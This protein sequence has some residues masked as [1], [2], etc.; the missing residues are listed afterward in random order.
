MLRYD[1][2]NFLIE[3]NKYNKY[4]EIGVRN[5]DDCFNII[6]CETKYSVDPCYEFQGYRPN[7][8]YTSDE[9]FNLLDSNMLDLHSDYNWDIIF[10][11]GLHISNQVEK[12]ILNS[13]NHLSE[14]GIIVLHD[15][16][17][18]DIW[19]AREDY[20]IDGVAH[21][22]NGTVWKAVYKLRATRPDLFVCTVDTDYGI[23]L[24]KKGT[25]KCC[26]FDNEY[27]EY[28]KFETDKKKYLNLISVEEFKKIF[29]I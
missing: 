19:F 16:N 24:I 10:I 18:S 8:Q 21:G 25:Q 23:G 9:F 27:Y 6:E 7:Y 2:I 29:N 13:L 5:P 28:R 11:D 20:I 26:E 17:P 12:D 4:L 3:K 14:N 15:C 1:I 22:W